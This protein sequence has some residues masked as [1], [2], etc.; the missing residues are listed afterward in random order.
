MKFLAAAFLFLSCAVGF[1]QTQTI[2]GTATDSDGQVWNTG[3]YKIEFVP[4]P[5]SPNISSYFVNGSTPLSTYTLNFAGPLTTSGSFTQAGIVNNNNITPVGSKWRFYICPHASSPCGVFVIAVT[6]DADITTIVNANIKA[7]RFDAISGAFGYN[8]TEANP[9]L[10]SGSQYYNVLNSCETY[11]SAI[12]NLWACAGVGSQLGTQVQI[13][14]LGVL[15]T[16]DLNLAGIT[17]DAGYITLPWKTNAGKGTVETPLFSTVSLYGTVSTYIDSTSG[18][19]T[20]GF[21]LDAEHFNGS[22]WQNTFYGTGSPTSFGATCSAAFVNTWYYDL[23]TSPINQWKCLVLAG[24]TYTWTQFGTAGAPV[25]VCGSGQVPCLNTANEWTAPV[26]TFDAA[27]PISTPIYVKQGAS[28]TSSSLIQ[29]RTDGAGAGGART[30]AYSNPLI[31]GDELV[32]FCIITGGNS[33]PHVPAV[34]DTQGNV[35][36]EITGSVIGSYYGN[37]NIWTAT[38]SSSGADSVTCALSSNASGGQQIVITEYTALS[39][40]LDVQTQVAPASGSWSVGPVTTGFP[41]VIFS[42]F[43]A[44]G[45]SYTAA[46]PSGAF[47]TLAADGVN[48]NIAVDMNVAASTPVTANWNT[49]FTGSGPLGWIVAIRRQTQNQSADMLS[50]K[51]PLGTILPPGLD[52]QLRL[53]SVLYSSENVAFSSTPTFSPLVRSS[54]ITLTGN[55][56]TF[57]LVGGQQGEE[58][59]LCF[60]QDGVGGRTVVPPSNVKNFFSISAAINSTSCQHFTYSLIASNWYADSAGGVQPIGTVA[61][62]IGTSL[63]AANSCTSVATASLN[64]IVTT[65]AL[66]AT[67]NADI[68]TVTGWGTTGGLVLFLYPTTNTINY[69]ACNQTTAGITPSSSVTFNVGLSK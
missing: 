59:T 11:Y 20:Q 68:S 27:T 19:H 30:L 8:D 13:N 50:I 40:L 5:N 32:V 65:S 2:S 15:P 66:I 58:K 64:G 3:T 25:G 6:A 52:N 56:T 61:I 12:T 49:T 9:H 10:V 23:G 67:A 60:T 35:F 41:D 33:V 18:S 34:T 14:S 37:I 45:G 16:L 46:S 31:A 54:F 43:L 24:P 48:Y 62:T 47:S 44:S 39:G 63:I 42:G 26:Q 4:N 57:T 69:R 21:P 53:R 36:T 28:A 38:A 1:A 22:N 55:I 7:P 51:D 29:I 17:P